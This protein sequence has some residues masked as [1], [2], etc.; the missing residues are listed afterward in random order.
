MA[1][2]NPFKIAQAQLDTAA[3]TLGL[4]YVIDPMVALARLQH[5]VAAAV[6]AEVGQLVIHVKSAHIY[7][8][9]FAAMRDLVQAAV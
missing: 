3:K 7:E 9:E 4:D 6:G 5:E 1:E 2:L 8:P